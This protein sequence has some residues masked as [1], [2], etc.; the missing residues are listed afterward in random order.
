MTHT[1][2]VRITCN[3]AIQHLDN[4][5]TQVAF[6]RLHS[7]APEL[8]AACIK[9]E[10]TLNIIANLYGAHTEGTAADTLGARKALCAAIAKAK[11]A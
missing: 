10:E 11:G 2:K 7:Y 4:G 1:P 3:C 8:L 5:D 6:C 9:A